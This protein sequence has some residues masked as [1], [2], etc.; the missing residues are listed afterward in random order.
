[1][2]ILWTIFTIV[3]GP[4]SF[5]RK[6]LVLGHST[7]FWGSLLG[8]VP[9]FLLVF[10]LLGM[11]QVLLGRTDTLSKAGLFFTLLGLLIPATVDLIAGS[12][13]PPLFVPAVG[14]GLLLIALSHWRNPGLGK[15][16]VY[17]LFIMGVLQLIAFASVLIPGHFFDQMYG[18]R[19]QGVLAYVLMGIG[20]ISLGF[21][22]LL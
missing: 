7:F 17:L 20:G 10:G 14:T 8:G 11:R 4:T 18:Y 2:I 16:R 22:F 9:N 12:L 6:G 21:S 19:I 5:D 13:G 3:H 15:R 1:M